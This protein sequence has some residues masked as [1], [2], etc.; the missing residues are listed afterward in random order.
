MNTVSNYLTVFLLLILT[1]SCSSNKNQE[2]QSEL[3]HLVNNQGFHGLTNKQFILVIPRTGCTGCI[4]TAE[5]F[6]MNSSKQYSHRLNILLTDI[7]SMKT[8]KI[9]FGESIN[10]Q[11][12]YIDSDDVSTGLLKSTIYPFIIELIDNRVINLEFVSPENP[13]AILNLEAKLNY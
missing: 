7:I 5:E 10:N 12:W 2:V 9:K 11:Y 6:V 13:H 4:D 1:I 3:E 8:L